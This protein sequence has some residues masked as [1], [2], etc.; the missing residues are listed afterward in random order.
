MSTIE[1][2]LQQRAQ[3]DAR[4]QAAKSRESQAERKADTRRK[5]L[6]GAFVLEAIGGNVAALE[7]NG[8]KLADFIQRDGDRA[9]FNLPAVAQAQATG[10]SDGL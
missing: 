2:L 7:I 5:V 1:K 8:R 10:V 4:I 6:V 9:L 3:L